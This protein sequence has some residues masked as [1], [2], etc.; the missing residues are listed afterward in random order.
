[1]APEP[2][3][4]AHLRPALEPGYLTADLLDGRADVAMDITDIQ[5]PDGS[6]DV[7]YCSHVL[8]HVPEDR[9]A[10]REL[11]RVMAPAGWGMINVPIAVAVTDEDPSVT[12]PAERLRRFGKDDHVR[13]YGE[14][15][16][17]RQREAGFEVEVATAADLMGPAELERYGIPETERLCIC[18]KPSTAG[19]APQR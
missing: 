18:R 12:D 1:M 2:A 4:E 7:I 19:E 9:K 8:E 5:Y 15:Y 6:F 3:L 16:F 13:S 17:D 11:Y 10:M 14:D